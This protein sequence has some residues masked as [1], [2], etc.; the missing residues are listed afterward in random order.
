MI[1]YLLKEPHTPDFKKKDI[2]EKIDDIFVDKDD[3]NDS[4]DP[5]Y[6]IKMNISSNFMGTFVQADSDSPNSL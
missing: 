4:K 1:H 5:M 3:K 2:N 6:N